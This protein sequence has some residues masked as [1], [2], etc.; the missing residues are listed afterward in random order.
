MLTKDKSS[1][2]NKNLNNLSLYNIDKALETAFFYGF[3]PIKTPQA[4][5]D[6]CLQ[7]KSFEN[8]LC[9]Q[10]IN[11]GLERSH[12]M[13]NKIYLLRTYIE[14]GFRSF[15]FPLSICYRDKEEY[16]KNDS[17]SFLNLS[18]LGSGSSVAEALALKTSLAILRDQEV[19]NLKI[20]INSVGDK[21]SF[22]KFEKELS[23]F[24]KKNAEVLPKDIIEIIKKEPNDILK[25]DLE[26]ENKEMM[27]NMPKPLNFL[28]PQAIKHFKEVLEYLE[29]FETP[30]D[31]NHSLIPNKQYCSQTIFQIKADE[32]V[33]AV[34][35]RHHN[36]VRK[37]HIRKEIP[38]L[39]VSIKDN[40]AKVKK[41]NIRKIKPKYFLVQFGNK[42]K[43]KCLA[44]IES[45]RKARIPI[46]HSLTKDKL[47]G[48]LTTAENLNFPYILIIGEK[49]ALEQSVVVRNTET[50]VQE[51]VSSCDLVNYLRKLKI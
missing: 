31:L 2:L 49:E 3:I 18:I 8:G 19:K 24:V 22:G 21:E 20:E 33:V 51:T 30:Y 29:F 25:K 15:P 35:V 28:T 48:Q 44:L 43:A 34:G 38:Y 6:D 12:S 14:G 42:A 23:N 37:L 5:K 27:A 39:S 46:Y 45:L 50:R 4:S 17:E 11:Q 9:L 13:N 16:K 7:S 40:I 32:A 1:S 26:D 41:T 10:K 47:M 36:I